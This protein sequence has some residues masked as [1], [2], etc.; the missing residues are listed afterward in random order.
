MK[1]LFFKLYNP[2]GLFNQVTSIEIGVGLAF[3]TN[4]EIV[5]HNITNPPNSDYNNNRVSIYSANSFF[6]D[7]K[8]LLEN[9]VYPKI[10]DLVDWNNKDSQIF[11]DDCVDTFSLSAIKIDNL[12]EYYLS[13]EIDL[14]FSE[15]RKLL[16]FDDEFDYD[17]RNT[18][19]YYSRFFKNKNISFINE[20][21]S[22]RFKKEYYELAEIIAKSLGNFS[23]AHLRL[24]DHIVR[25]NTTS[26]IFDSG[27]Q[28]IRQDLPIVLSTD[29]PNSNIVKQSDHKFI[30]LDQYI[31]ENFYKDFKQL[32]FKE[33]VSFGLLNN[34]VMHYSQDFIGTPGSTYT[35]YI[36]RN[37]NK[38]KDIEFKL[39]GEDGFMQSG[40]YSWNGHYHDT[41]TKQWWREWKES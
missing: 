24:T 9:N 17:I 3:K 2:C 41:I 19:G 40:P 5:W 12:M 13:E 11:I 23:G 6:N 4:R 36:H 22:I 21:S 29:E 8:N 39:F 35:G 15:S 1:K 27:L 30:L 32:K 38:R 31:L 34:L 14:D 26:E 18:L 20:I 37:I 33:E 16:K 28:K 10:T 7:R 25:V